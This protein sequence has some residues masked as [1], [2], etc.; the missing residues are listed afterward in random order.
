MF[1]C[2][3]CGYRAS[4]KCNMKAHYNRKW[5][6]KPLRSD[7]SFET[8][9]EQFHN[10][11]AKCAKNTL[12][13]AENALKY[14]ENTLKYAEPK[15]KQFKCE[16]CLKVFKQKRYLKQHINR[17]NCKE[18]NQNSL[19][20]Y[21]SLKMSK[22]EADILEMK[23]QHAKEI[24]VLL[25]KVG[26]GGLSNSTNNSTNNSNNR[27]NHIGTQQNI[28]GNMT[29]NIVLNNFGK[30]DIKYI[31]EEF[32]KNLMKLPYGSIPKLLKHV[33]FN[34]E[35]PENRNVKITNKKL[36]WAE[37]WNEDKWELRDKKQVIDD[38]V[39]KGYNM[40]DE[41]YDRDPPDL[42]INKRKNFE[43]FQGKYDKEDKDTHKLLNKGVETLVLNES[44]NVNI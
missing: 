29:Q 5:A 44:K 12:K 16:S 1:L 21:M 17:G 33:H 10:N 41:Q 30:E 32:V 9:K 19:L 14:A 15:N 8:L 7:I 40:I 27:T 4:Y 25:E 11:D 35:H 43:D 24:E 36:S 37:V 31:T 23:K 6:C 20:E 3:R 34:P 18:N 39:D 2:E 42:P 22:M 38:M 13:Y 26:T 28:G